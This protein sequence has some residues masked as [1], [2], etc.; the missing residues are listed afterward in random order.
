[1]ACEGGSYCESM[2]PKDKKR[3][4]NDIGHHKIKI[5]KIKARRKKR[6]ESNTRIISKGKF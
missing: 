3:P 1:M 2:V 4:I 6:R 5:K